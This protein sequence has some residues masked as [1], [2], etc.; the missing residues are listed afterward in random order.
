ME[1][2]V[3][4]LKK[5]LQ[6]QIELYSKIEQIEAD[7][8]EV[9]IDKNGK[10]LSDLVLEQEK[11]IKI[12]SKLENKRISIIDDYISDNYLEDISSNIS[13]KMIITS[14]D[15]DSAH[16]IYELG[17]ELKQIVS[18]IKQL[19][20]TNSILLN[21]NLEFFNI[22]SESLKGITVETGAYSQSGDHAVKTMTES[23]LFN[24]TV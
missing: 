16:V 11:Y 7:K 14:M 18:N 21:D 1:R 24:K 13:L 9:I 8:S 4:E 20:K 19:N 22:L 12:L 5:N 10:M 2:N 6:E 17:R 23:V 3:L 15:E